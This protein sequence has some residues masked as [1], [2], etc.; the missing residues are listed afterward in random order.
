M[1]TLS[2]PPNLIDAAAIIDTA[3]ASFKVRDRVLRLL[4]R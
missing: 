2:Q 1:P 3:A 4:S